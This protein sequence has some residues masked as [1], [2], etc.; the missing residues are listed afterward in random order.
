MANYTDSLGF[1]KNSAAFPAK[2]NDAVS[3]VSVTLDFAK[4]AAARSAAGVA[5]L[6][7]TDT[8][9][10]L[11]LPAGALV[12]A[13]GA[14]VTKAEG[15]TATMDVGDS[16]SATRY[17]SNADLNATGNTASALTSPYLYTAAGVLRITL[18]HSSVDTAVV[19]IYAVI[20]NTNN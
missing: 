5:A 1:Y 11:P 19:R 14:Q 6:A 9:E 8:L 13:V 12:L 7:A 18:D 16:G 17:L 20:V 15:A 3:V 2:N 10:V 4:I